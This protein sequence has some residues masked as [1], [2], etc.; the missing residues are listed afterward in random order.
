MDLSCGYD[1]ARRLLVPVIAAQITQQ[2]SSFAR[3]RAHRLF[4]VPD[5]QPSSSAASSTE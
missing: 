3:A 4:T 5:G 1:G 2:G